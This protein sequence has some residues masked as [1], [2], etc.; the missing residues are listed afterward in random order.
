MDRRRDTHQTTMMYCRVLNRKGWAP[1]PWHPQ[2]NSSTALCEEH[3][4]ATGNFTPGA[5]K[6]LARFPL[7]H[8]R[9]ILVCCRN[10]K[11]QVFSRQ[12]KL[13][14]YFVYT[15]PSPQMK[16]KDVYIILFCLQN[17][18]LVGAWYML[19]PKLICRNKK[20]NR[21]S[22]LEGLIFR[23]TG[24]HGPGWSWQQWGANNIGIAHA[25]A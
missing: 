17:H 10:T 23:E 7:H 12:Y 21:I 11:A 14:A 5:R 2:Q 13:K 4:R 20:L 16:K 6:V 24:V 3:P 18:L 19:N 15:I 8:L 9:V 1:Y 22:N 25:Y